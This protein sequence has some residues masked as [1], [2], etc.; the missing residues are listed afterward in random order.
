MPDLLA[1]YAISYLIASRVEKPRRAMALALIGLLPD[2]DVLLRIHRWVTHS[3]VLTVLVASVAATAALRVAPHSLERIALGS[4]LY[5]VHLLLDL[6]TAPTPILWPL[7]SEAYMVEVGLDGV[8]S[9]SGI[10]LIP[11]V[12]V[13]SEA[14]DFSPQ[15]AIEGPLVST[16]GIMIA[17]GVA[18]M[19]L[20]ERLAER[21]ASAHRD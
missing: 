10:D 6:F 12:T 14:A 13:I 2:L 5:A 21:R 16:I 8:V 18:A 11:R 15:L 7:S 20:A 3:L 19:A 1:H 17:S 4:G 9:A